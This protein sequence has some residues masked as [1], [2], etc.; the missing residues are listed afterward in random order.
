MMRVASAVCSL[1]Q[2]H[3][4]A[5]LPP[6]EHVAALL[7][8]AMPL[9]AAERFRQPMADLD[10]LPPLLVTQACGL[11]GVPLQGLYV[12]DLPAAA[13]T[14]AMPAH[15]GLLPFCLDR[16]E[17]LGDQARLSPTGLQLPLMRHAGQSH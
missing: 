4:R 11:L 2:S 3:E 15:A 12:C 16:A 1:T 7:S 13:E 6:A 10:G 17:T 5:P 9:Q 8:L 14:A